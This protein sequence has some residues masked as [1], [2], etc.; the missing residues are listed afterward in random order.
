MKAPGFSGRNIAAMKTLETDKSIRLLLE[1]R[2]GAITSELTAETA[3]E[4]DLGITGDNALE[5]MLEFSELYHVNLDRF[6][7]K[8]YFEPEEDRVLLDMLRALFGRKHPKQK[9]LTIGHLLAAI[10]AGRL[11]DEVIASSSSERYLFQCVV[12]FVRQETGE[13]QLSMEPDTSLEEAL[14]ITGDD[15]AGLIRSFSRKFH[16]SL[17]NFRFEEH[18]LPEPGML[19]FRKE[20]KPLTLGHLERALV[21]GHLDG[22]VILP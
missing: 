3:L 15:A 1:S 8:A 11:D 13:Y 2:M 9:E 7:F 10:E 4:R 20:L 14:G 22:S 21:T 18:F 12:D 17:R 16:V 6:D 5:F 19:P